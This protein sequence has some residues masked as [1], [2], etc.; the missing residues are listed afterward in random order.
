[1][2]H[3]EGGRPALCPGLLGLLGGS[4]ILPQ[5]PSSGRMREQAQG[6]EACRPEPTAPGTELGAAPSSVVEDVAGCVKTGL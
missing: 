6:T 1:M 3:R 2:R 5:P 4:A